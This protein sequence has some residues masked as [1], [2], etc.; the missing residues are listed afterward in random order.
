M[1]HAP[2]GHV[3][4]G[5]VRQQAHV[6]GPH[7]AAAVPRVVQAVQ[8][9]VRAAARALRDNDRLWAVLLDGL[10][11]LLLDDVERLVPRDALPLALAALAGALQGVLEAVGMRVDLLGRERLDAQDAVVHRIVLIALHA[12]DLVVVVDREDDAALG[13]AVE[14][15]GPDFLLHD[16][17]RIVSLVSSRS[18]AFPD[19]RAR[20]SCP[21][22][23]ARTGT[24]AGRE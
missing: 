7:L 2:V 24:R 18:S 17:L 21:S 3:R 23:R 16:Y 13:M 22:S 4:L 19:K 9:V 5:Q 12:H 8:E 10:A 20:T 1:E 11:D 6:R 15:D 14:T